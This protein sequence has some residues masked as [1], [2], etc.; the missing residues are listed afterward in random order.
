VDAI[1]TARRRPVDWL[2]CAWNALVIV[3]CSITVAVLLHLSNRAEG[4][5]VFMARVR[6]SHAGQE[7]ALRLIAAHVGVPDDR[8][9]EA[10]ATPER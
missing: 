10:F 4:Y 8:I 3:L 2:S 1:P 7:A 9:E 5:E 6:H